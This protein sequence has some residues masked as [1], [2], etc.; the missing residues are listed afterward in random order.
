MVPCE[1]CEG[2]LEW[3]DMLE[4]WE[5]AEDGEDGE[6]SDNDDRGM[7]VST[8]TSDSGSESSELGRSSRRLDTM[9]LVQAHFH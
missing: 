2:E 4:D 8:C 3:S 7:S 5:D 6:E 1:W 9:H